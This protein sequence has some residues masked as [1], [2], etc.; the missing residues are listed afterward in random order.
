MIVT[1]KITSVQGKILGAALLPSGRSGEY[2]YAVDYQLLLKQARTL[3]SR[4][5]ISIIT[6]SLLTP[7]QKVLLPLGMS[8]IF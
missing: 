7:Q 2:K 3:T 1:L 5:K 6:Q 4:S 8:R